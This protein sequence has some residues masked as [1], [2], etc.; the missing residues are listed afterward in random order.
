[1]ILR[2]PRRLTRLGAT[3]AVAMLPL[4]V[5]SAVN[6]QTAP[7]A[8][9][10]KVVSNFNGASIA[11]G[12]YIWFSAVLT[13]VK[14]LDPT[15]KTTVSFTGS[16]IESSNFSQSAPDAD[17]V[18]DPA[19]TTATTTFTGGKW[20]TTVPTSHLAGNVFLDGLAFQVP[21]G[22]LPGGIKP[23][24]WSG[25]FSSPTTGLTAQWS[26]GAAVYTTFSSDYNAL[27][28]KPVDD[29]KASV[30]KNSDHAGTPENFKPFV[31][32][33][34]TGGGAGNYTGGLGGT[35][36]CPIGAGGGGG[37]GP[38]ACQPSSSLTVLVQGSDVS[39]YVP[40]GHWGSSATGVG[41]VPVE[42][43]GALGPA[44]VAT[45]NTVNSC[46]SNFV[47]G[48]TACT[49]NNTDVY[50][51]SGTSLSSTLTSGGSGSIFFSGGACTNCGVAM[52]ATHNK[53]LIG[54]SDGGAPGFQ[55]LDLGSSTFEPAFASPSGLISEDPLVDP[56]RNFL[57]SASE[58]NNYEIVN[59]ADTTAPVFYENGPIA[60]DGDLDSSGEDCSTGIALAPAEFSGP[61]EVYVADLTQATFTPGLP[62]G[63][64]SAPSQIQT[65]DESFLDAGASGIAVAQGTHTG[66][67]S[68]EFGGDAI[69]AIALPSTSGTGTPAI[70]DW[71]TCS[72]GNGFDNGFDPHTVTAYK[73]PNSGDAISLLA[74]GDASSL[75]DVDLTKM[76]DPTTVPR[77]V[78]GHGCASGT[79]PS[80]V[81]SFIPVP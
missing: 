76:L 15:K 24:T 13:K 39:A 40:K 25:T 7:S 52:D 61:S 11:A 49:A 28:V 57:L 72:I 31:T 75:A 34:A 12:N 68:G 64:W 46:A 77:T 59:V 2:I 3:V 45:P 51:L 71:V 18:F 70:T 22:G 56:F 58:N 78:G 32:G 36:A 73:S 38:T 33:G 4:V 27:G 19:A 48:V 55:F 74:N 23:V 60:A 6:A 17:V 62:S 50:L 80:S 9:E 66:I 54:L 37:G 53:A 21:A 69:T 81:V 67:V 5:S 65:L 14:G 29:N 10:C 63:T 41:V 47:T 8:T 42:G 43:A 35:S 1:M 20:V 79:L 16:K 26:W 44:L 30:Y